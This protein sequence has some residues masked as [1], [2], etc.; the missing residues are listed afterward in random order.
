[1]IAELIPINFINFARYTD[2]IFLVS[3]VANKKDTS[4]NQAIRTVVADYHHRVSSFLNEIH[5]EITNFNRLT[6]TVISSEAQRGV[7]MINIINGTPPLGYF[8]ASPNLP[9]LAYQQLQRLYFKD[10]L[11]TLR[12]HKSTRPIMLVIHRIHNLFDSVGEVSKFFQLMKAEHV[13]VIT[14]VLVNDKPNIHYENIIREV[15]TNSS[16][17]FIHNMYEEYLNTIIQNLLKNTRV[18]RPLYQFVDLNRKYNQRYI[19]DITLEE[20]NDAAVRK[21]M[22]E[23]LKNIPAGKI[24]LKTIDNYC[25][26]NTNVFYNTYMNTVQFTSYLT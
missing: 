12:N 24:I 3:D 16:N 1:M 6:K 7:S 17:L 5:H 21:Q 19:H 25:N 22:I 11:I 13:C 20:E 4:I 9:G 15:I 14:D 26:Q 10:F 23:N 18:V 2:P 8:N